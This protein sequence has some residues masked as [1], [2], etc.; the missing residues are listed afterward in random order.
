MQSLIHPVIWIIFYKDRFAVYA[1]G[2]DY[3]DIGKEA[4]ALVARARL[5]P[6]LVVGKIQKGQDLQC[7]DLVSIALGLAR[8]AEECEQLSLE[9]SPFVHLP[10]Q[11]AA[12]ARL[13][14]FRARYGVDE[15]YALTIGE[16]FGEEAVGVRIHSCCFTGDVLGSRKCDCGP[17]LKRALTWM[18]ENKGG[19][20]L[21]LF[22]EGRGIGL[23][24][25]IRAYH[26]QDQGFDTFT[27]NEKMGF[28]ADLRNFA[29]AAEMLRILGRHQIRLLTNNHDKAQALRQFGI[30]VK[31]I[32]PLRAGENIHNQRYLRDKAQRH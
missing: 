26:L 10:I 14:G 13:I 28:S 17:Q 9:T 18:A 25:K 24:N 21:Y 3:T 31:A 22:Q 4:M 30:V 8:Q 29:V 12:D 15:H 6:C 2:Q 19:V 11:Q 23:F 7:Q 20:L 32:I 16:P 27:A 1:D 5:L